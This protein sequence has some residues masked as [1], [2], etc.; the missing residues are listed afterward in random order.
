MPARLQIWVELLHTA[1]APFGVE[2]PQA[3]T[4]VC[5]RDGA[6]MVMSSGILYNIAGGLTAR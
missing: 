2:N 3:M 4:S 6:F 1:A 5:P